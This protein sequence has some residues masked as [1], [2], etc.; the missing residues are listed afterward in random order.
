MKKRLLS[1]L[2]TMCM[3]MTLLPA[4]H[5]A[6]KIYLALG[7]SITAGYGLADEGE[8][9][10]AIVAAE[11]GYTL[12]NR[13]VNGNTAEGISM[14]LSDPDVLIDVLSA[15]VITITCGGNDLMGLVFT[16]AADAFNALSPVKIKAWQVSQIL[17]DPTDE[18]QMT[19]LA[20]LQQLLLGDAQ[21]PAL[22][23]SPVM[24]AALAAFEHG[25]VV[26]VDGRNLGNCLGKGNVDRA[27]GVHSKVELVGNLL[28]GAFFGTETAT[29]TLDLVNIAG[30]FLDLNLEIADKTLYGFYLGVRVNVNFLVLRSIYHLRCKDTG[31]AV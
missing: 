4:A 15:D 27:A 1:L 2:L 30:F 21:T 11:K 14:Q 5:A 16:Q 25:A 20:L 28:L 23:D 3:V 8:C 17:S 6:E 31:S 29:R 9:F 7:D 18:R 24:D 12:I 13:A 19:L 22:A 26:R 10:A